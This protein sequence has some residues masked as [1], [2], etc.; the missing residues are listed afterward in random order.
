M[1][2][3]EIES[4]K[5]KRLIAEIQADLDAL[6]EVQKE[7]NLNWN[8]KTCGLKSHTLGKN[9]ATVVALLV[10]VWFFTLGVN[11]SRKWKS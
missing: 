9:N 4:I 1:T 7:E 2:E 10:C 11:S 8:N 5:L 6:L 3:N